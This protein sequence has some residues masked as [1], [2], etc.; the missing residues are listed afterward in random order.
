MSDHLRLLAEPR[1]VEILRLVWDRE[2]SAGA[3]AER[4]PVSF[5]A[6]SQHLRKLLDAG[7]VTRRK[8]GRYRYYRARKSDMGT[9]QIYLESMWQDRL[10]RLRDIA[11]CEQRRRDADGEG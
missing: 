6:V 4:L 9:L 1:R 11:E 3:I 8:E 2:L 7:L 10:E 5:A